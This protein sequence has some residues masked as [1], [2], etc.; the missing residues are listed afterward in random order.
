MA[1][2]TRK[3]LVLRGV[4]VVSDVVTVLER[5]GFNPARVQTVAMSHSPRRPHGGRQ[6]M[7]PT[8]SLASAADSGT[9][10]AVSR[11]GRLERCAGNPS[12]CLAITAGRTIL[13]RWSRYSLPY[14]QS[15]QGQKRPLS[16]LKRGPAAPA[17]IGRLECTR[18]PLGERGAC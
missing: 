12:R 5:A 14:P 13:S 7:R 4:R 10:G 18:R 6:T 8:T 9:A 11:A 16:W 3:N 17:F 2:I 15:Q 1:V